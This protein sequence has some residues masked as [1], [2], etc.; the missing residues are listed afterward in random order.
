MYTSISNFFKNYEQFKVPK[1]I[2]NYSFVEN[3][4]N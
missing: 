3:N 4:M 2:N 1:L